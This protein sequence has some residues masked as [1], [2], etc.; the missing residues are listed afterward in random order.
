M[1]LSKLE[2]AVGIKCSVVDVVCGEE[3][4]RT[5]R[6]GDV[7][8]DGEDHLPVL[9]VQESGRFVEEDDIGTADQCDGRAGLLEFSVADPA[10]VLGFDIMQPDELILN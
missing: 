4:G 3:D 6:P 8:E 10:E 7:P 2:V 5:G 9:H 1:C